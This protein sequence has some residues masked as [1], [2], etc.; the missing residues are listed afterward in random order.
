MW[1][2]IGIQ[3]FLIA[4]FS[5]L[6]WAIVKKKIYG[7]ISN[8]NGRS[9]EEQRQLIELGYPQ[10]VGKLL[11]ATAGG[12]AALLPLSFTS[13]D[14][15]M[16]IQFGFMIV[17]LLG[18]LVYL[19]KYEIPSKRKRSYIVS[20][21]IAAGT[22]GFL[23]V[24]IYVGYQ[25]FELKTHEDSFEITGMYGDEWN[26]SEIVAVNLLDEMPTVT[27]KQD[28]FGMSTIAKGRFTVEEY[29][30]S[31]LFVHKGNAPYLYIELK[32]KKIFINS[33]NPLQ[34][35]EWQEKLNRHGN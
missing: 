19:S 14:Y 1:F 5:I 31:L 20:S 25:D 10:R 27:W 32:D 8:F 28:G 6:G 15:A 29:G 9:D 4:L 33:K 18:G 34:T 11:L 12:M 21:L 30:T 23:G 26:Y 2:L 3:L 22:I 35:K 16:D 24:L 7:L 13:F 17:F